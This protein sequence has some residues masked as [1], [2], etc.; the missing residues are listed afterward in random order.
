MKRHNHP[1]QATL[2]LHAGGDLGRFTAWRTS[3][4]VSQCEEC[5]EEVTAFQ[6]MRERLPELNEI[7][8]LPWNR[9]ASEMRANIRL[10][11]AAGECVRESPA[12]VLRTPLFTGA[13]MAIAMASVLALIVTGVVLERPTDS[14]MSAGSPSVQTTLDGIQSRTGN[15]GFALMHKGADERYVSYTPGAAGTM[16]ASY[17]DPKT[18]YV[19]MTKVY[20]E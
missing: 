19:T 16:G 7:P 2:A 12:L 8:D 4:H 9:M 15:Q 20:V 3:R 14:I 6:E 5:R 18:D 11:L 17:V 1:E 10:G 13:R